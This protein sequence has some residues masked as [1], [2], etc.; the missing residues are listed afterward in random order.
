MTTTPLST[1]LGGPR[2][3]APAPWSAGRIFL[4]VVGALGMLLGVGLLV[5]GGA[6]A[7]AAQ[8]RDDGYLT[9]GEAPLHSDGH[10]VDIR[11]IGVGVHGPDIATARDLLGRVRVRATSDDAGRP[12]F[13]GLAPR[14][15][16]DRYL[17]GVRNDEV[18]DFDLDPYD[19]DYRQHAG[20]APASR[21]GDQSFWT[22]SDAGTGTR[23]V[24]W[25]VAPGDWAIVVMNAD[26]SA[27][28]DATVDLGASTPALRLAAVGFLVVGLSALVTGG[29]IIALAIGT[30]QRSPY[31]AVPV[32]PR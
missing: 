8:G 9:S 27:G 20:G 11:Q 3:P 19:V 12:L 2:A 23:E 22:V 28:V 4:V 6:L 10:A 30:R 32:G 13:V 26:A 17:A 7:V 24:T 1:S 18:L 31:T 25:D 21:P 16:V 5:A 14:A 15:D 29:V